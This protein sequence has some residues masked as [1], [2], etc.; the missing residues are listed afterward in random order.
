MRKIVYYVATSIDGFISGAEGDISGFV[1]KSDAVEKYQQDLLNFDTVI[2]GRKT[3]EFGYRYGLV[4][5][6]PAYPH[7]K[8]FIFS[9]SL[10]FETQSPQVH[11]CKLDIGLVKE[12]KQQ[13]GSDIYLCGGG[14]FAGWLLEHQMVDTLKIKLNPFI[15]GNG[16][17]LFEE[18]QGMYNL[19]F[20]HGKQYTKG[21]QIIEYQIIY[22]KDREF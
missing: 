10:R 9:G 22:G 20:I 12:L 21:V 7:M 8:H 11:V 16:I 6:Q 15:A 4:P 17:S 19:K 13:K 14:Q 5:G 2:M 3:Y 18:V 1:E